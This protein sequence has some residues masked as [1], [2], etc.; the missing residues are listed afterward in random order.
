MSTP[1]FTIYYFVWGYNACWS[2]LSRVITYPASLSIRTT[3]HQV[4]KGRHYIP[5]HQTYHHLFPHKLSTCYNLWITH[6]GG[7]ITKYII[8]HGAPTPIWGV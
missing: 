2:L 7:G 3:E 5:P 1:P 6:K 8:W 4:H